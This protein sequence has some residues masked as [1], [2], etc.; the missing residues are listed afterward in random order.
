MN[1][2]LKILLSIPSILII[3]AVIYSFFTDLEGE[4]YFLY[5]N[6]LIVFQIIYLLTLIYIVV[7]LWKDERK[8]KNTKWTWTL[9]MIFFVQPIT[10]LVYLWA[11]EPE[12]KKTT[13]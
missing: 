13:S 11:V 6:T 8:T 3:I 12:R 1:K 2:S 9:L 5:F 10:T 7:Q 4:Q